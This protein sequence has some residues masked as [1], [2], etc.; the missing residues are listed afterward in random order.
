MRGNFLGGMAMALMGAAALTGCVHGVPELAELRRDRAAICV[1]AEEM[2]SRTGGVGMNVV[3]GQGVWQLGDGKA[4]GVEAAL[5]A[6]PSQWKRVRIEVACVQAEATT[7][8]FVCR[9][10]LSQPE[11]KALRSAPLRCA[12]G[13]GVSVLEFESDFSVTGGSPLTVGVVREAADELDS[14]PGHLG[15]A[16]IRVSQVEELYA[17][18]TVQDCPGYNSWPM[19][20]ALGKRLVCTYSRGTGHNIG[21]KVRG[22]FARTSDD[23][24]QTWSPETLVTNQ[25]D[26]GEVT[27]G[28]GL[29]EQG[30][31]LLW[32]RCVG[33]DWRHELYRTKDGVAFEKIAT[34]RPKP[35]PM[36]IMDVVKVP[37]V[38]LM[39]LW[40]ASNYQDDDKNAWGTM[41]SRD[42]GLTWEQQVV[43][44]GM[45]KAELPTEQ[46]VVY[47]GNGRIFGLSRTEFIR[48]V[49]ANGQFQLESLD[50]GKTWTKRRTNI[51]DVLCST[52]S[53]VYDAKRGVLVN[54][55]FQRG[56]GILK[57]RVAR[58]EDVAANPLAWPAP[59]FLVQGSTS[60]FDTGNVNV[61]TIGQTHYACYYTGKH[62]QTSVVVAPIS[63]R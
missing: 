28:K 45:P 29:D 39:S 2:Q 43:E 51:T 18:L 50:Y 17:A 24:G 13:A 20:Q 3:S 44:Q 32:V 42:N 21:E 63:Y 33:P 35:M 61:T 46:S 8:E 23:G 10:V 19:I 11:R 57:R 56:R 36:Q 31:M 22:V 41:I 58:I 37:G 60:T 27:I 9:V 25:G 12:P 34:V 6:L 40:F 14:A 59:E 55:Y 53:V 54:Y 38:G 5:P 26:C 4:S 1:A 52:P 62:P 15:V 7:G 49:A 47:L 48:D 16:L 30:D